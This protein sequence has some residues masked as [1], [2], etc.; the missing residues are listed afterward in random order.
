[1]VTWSYCD[2]FKKT[3]SYL[4]CNH[5][6][7]TLRTFVG[8]SIYGVTEHPLL[9]PFGVLNWHMQPSTPKGVMG[10]LFINS[11]CMHIYNKAFRSYVRLIMHIIGLPC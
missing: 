8:Y 11:E 7:Y 5:R 9:T 2:C 1:M 4:R 6:Y 3:F 10:T